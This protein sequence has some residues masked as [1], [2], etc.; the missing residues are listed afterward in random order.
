MDLTVVDKCWVC[1]KEIAG[2]PGDLFE[3]RAACLT[4]AQRK[5]DRQMKWLNRFEWPMWFGSI[6]F[7]MAAGLWAGGWIGGLNIAI[8]W[9][10]VYAKVRGLRAMKARREDAA[11]TR[12][13]LEKFT[14]ASPDKAPDARPD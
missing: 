6:A 8:A 5:L 13:I 2:T 4:S 10:V 7:N 1:S 9:F 3:H 12:M 14:E 11:I